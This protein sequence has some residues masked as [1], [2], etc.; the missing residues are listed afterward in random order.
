MREAREAL[1]THVRGVL[2]VKVRMVVN[3]GSKLGCAVRRWSL[4]M[5]LLSYYCLAGVLEGVS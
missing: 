5:L 2:I 1:E 3:G 4:L